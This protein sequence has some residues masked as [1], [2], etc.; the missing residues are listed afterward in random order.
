MAPTRVLLATYQHSS[1]GIGAAECLERSQAIPRER[2]L[3]FFFSPTTRE[4]GVAW[5][6]VSL[7]DCIQHRD[8]VFFG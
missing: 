8:C 4:G 3:G 1:S 6:S 5:W 2:A 7:A